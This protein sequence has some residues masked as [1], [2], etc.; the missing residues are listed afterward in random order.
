LIALTNLWQDQAIA[1]GYQKSAYYLF[2]N[3][4]Q[5]LL[6]GPISIAL[7]ELTDYECPE[8]VFP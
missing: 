6:N 4:S 1:K 8:D 3:D 5:L 2:N 7:A